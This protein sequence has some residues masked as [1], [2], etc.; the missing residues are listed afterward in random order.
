MATGKIYIYIVILLCLSLLIQ[1]SSQSRQRGELSWLVKSAQCMRC[2]CRES[3]IQFIRILLWIGHAISPWYPAIILLDY[4]YRNTKR[5]NTLFKRQIIGQIH[6][7]IHIRDIS[8][9]TL[10]ENRLLLAAADDTTVGRTEPANCRVFEAFF[11][12][13]KPQPLQN[14]RVP[15]LRFT[16]KSYHPPLS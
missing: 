7:R 16:G 8:L 1:V 13:Q 6:A 15:C 11:L 14:S 12:L 5:N 2:S 10:Y 9:T 3:Y 4:F